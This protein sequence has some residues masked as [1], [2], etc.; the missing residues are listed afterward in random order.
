MMADYSRPTSLA[1]FFHGCENGIPF[2]S[3]RAISSSSSEASLIPNN[4][5]K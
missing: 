1:F 5:T 3:S 4:R 2:T